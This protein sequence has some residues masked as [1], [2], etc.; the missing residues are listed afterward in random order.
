[1]GGALLHP[2]AFVTAHYV[3]TTHDRAL[4]EGLMM[5]EHIYGEITADSWGD[6]GDESGNVLRTT[7]DI[8]LSLNRTVCCTVELNCGVSKSLLPDLYK[9]YNLFII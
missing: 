5:N 1:M 8:T 4:Q 7:S 6:G 9:N 3:L 2:H